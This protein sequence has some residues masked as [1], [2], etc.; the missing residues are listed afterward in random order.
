ML[1][2]PS[3]HEDAALHISHPPGPV[4]RL[5]PERQTPCG[6]DRRR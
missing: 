3:R 5:R 4:A 6:P 2:V 1:I